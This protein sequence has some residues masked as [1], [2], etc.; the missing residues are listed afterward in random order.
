MRPRILDAGC[1]RGDYAAKFLVPRGDVVAVDV[2]PEYIDSARQRYGDV[3]QWKCEPLERLSVQPRSFDEVYCFE[4]FE[5]VENYE[6]SLD[7]VVRALRRGGRL[8]MSVPH[9]RSER[10]FRRL[11]PRYFSPAMHRRFLPPRKLRRDLEAR[12]MRVARVHIRGFLAVLEVLYGFARGS[13]IEYG[14]GSPKRKDALHRALGFL[15]WLVGQPLRE[16]TR[17]VRRKK[18]RLISAAHLL[19]H[20]SV[21]AIDAILGRLLPKQT[22][23]EAEKVGDG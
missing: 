2:V 8:F 11:D 22:Y 12:G 19:V 1:G 20:V 4:V 13:G 16:R 15:N 6:T 23:I 7:N 14:L 5:H 17:H 18:G 9:P 3:A 10:I 21:K